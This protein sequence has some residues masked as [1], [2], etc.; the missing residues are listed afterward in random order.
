M[1]NYL[2]GKLHLLNSRY[3][4]KEAVKLI[5]RQTPNNF[6]ISVNKL[7]GHL[8]AWT[9]FYRPVFSHFKVLN[10]YVLDRLAQSL[11][12]VIKANKMWI[13][14]LNVRTEKRIKLLLRSLKRW[15]IYCHEIFYDYRTPYNGCRGKKVRRR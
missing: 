9:S 6:F 5:L 2:P 10:D 15:K 14:S 7:N 4:K 3:K 8:I 1:Q 11:L 12:P 13:W